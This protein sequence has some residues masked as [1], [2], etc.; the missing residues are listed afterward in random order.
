MHFTQGVL[1]PDLSFSLRLINSYA[2]DA[3]EILIMGTSFVF[4]L[5]I[6]Y[7]FHLNINE[8]GNL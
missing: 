8:L 4:E 2:V 1:G 5:C 7:F 6:L 3:E